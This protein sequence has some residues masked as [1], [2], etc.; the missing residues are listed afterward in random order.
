[1]KLQFTYW[2]YLG[3]GG[4]TILRL[5]PAVLDCEDCSF[6]QSIETIKCLVF[7]RATNQ[8]GPDY[9]TIYDQFH[10]ELS[11]LPTFRLHKNQRFLKLKYISAISSLEPELTADGT[12]GCQLLKAFC[13]EFKDVIESLKD[14][15]ILSKSDFDFHAFA[16][17]I[18]NSM[19][20]LPTSDG[21]IP[22]L[23]EKSSIIELRSFQSCKH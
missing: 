18:E 23:T 5:I 3:G 1:M 16:Q 7:F 9:R 14:D 19:E 8:P 4:H 21:E 11:E 20:N 12:T 22:A 10:S 6:G 15:P 13:L 2:I 17:H